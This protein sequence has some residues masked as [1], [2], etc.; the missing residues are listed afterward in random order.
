MITTLDFF[1]IGL[2]LT[3]TCICAFTDA[4]LDL[5]RTIITGAISVIS[6]V[7]ILA[8]IDPRLNLNLSDLGQLLVWALAACCGGG[9]TWFVFGPRF[10]HR[11]NLEVNGEPPRHDP[12]DNSRRPP[13]QPT[14]EDLGNIR[15][16]RKS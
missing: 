16:F 12:Q 4:R 1:L 15:R 6:G 2:W 9:L 13:L 10:N 7:T 8:R 14:S 11:G 3:V 5:R